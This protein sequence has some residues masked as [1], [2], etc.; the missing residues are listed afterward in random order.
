M[1]P[2]PLPFDPITE[3]RRQWERHGWGDSATGMSIVTSVMRAY[4]I[5]LGRG[6]AQGAIDHGEVAVHDLV[7]ARHQRPG[8]L[9][10]DSGCRWPR[11]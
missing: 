9:G 6:D 5:F 3:A 4:Q 11:A 1:S 8:T 2:S 7:G 10:G